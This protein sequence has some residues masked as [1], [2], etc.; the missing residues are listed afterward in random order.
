MAN[1]KFVWDGGSYTFD[2]NYTYAYKSEKQDFSDRARAVDGTLRTYSQ[3]LKQRWLLTFTY[4]P[5]AQKDQFAT[6]K[7]LQK[8]LEFYADADEALTMNCQW[9]NDFN[10]R[11]AAP[12]LWNGTIELE[13]L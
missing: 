11:E 4:I 5:T 2:K 9:V 3:V 8:D 6:I 13:E 1:G 7:A 12:G 10:F